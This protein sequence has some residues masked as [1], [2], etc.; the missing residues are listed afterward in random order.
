MIALRW[1]MLLAL[2]LLAGT[3]Q[4]RAAPQDSAASYPA[5][6]VR[7]IVPFA[8]GGVTDVMGRLLAQKLSERLG[9]EFYVDN[10]AGAGG[11]IGTGV[12]AAAAADGYT[13][14]LTSSS[15]VV[16]PS[17]HAKIPYDPNRD[18]VP[19]TIAA[20]S[21]N[22][23]VINPSVPARTVQELVDYIRKN[24][25]QA[26][27]A[28]AGIG[29]TP[30]LSGEMFRLSLGLDMV[31]VPFGGAGP[32]LQS[33]LA[34]HTPIAFTALPPAVPLVIA[35]ELRAL[36]VT[37]AKRSPALPD[38]P[39]MAEAGLHDQEVETILPILVPAATPKPIIDL[40]YGE[41]ARIIALPDTQQTLATLGFDP[42]ASTPEQSAVRVKEELARWAKVIRDAKIEPQ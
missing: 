14:L 40:L 35:G 24:P 16:N 22:L 29:T 18:L 17:L 23:L 33:A 38:V 4:G 10:R 39:T 8:P 15:Y 41:I 19:I 28:S 12:A 21:P 37:S 25:G 9:K 1:T 13:L 42:L 2:L 27:F 30:H 32:A 11:N 6:P 36:A 3:S 20:V 34:G 5:R 26:S 7:V 31:H